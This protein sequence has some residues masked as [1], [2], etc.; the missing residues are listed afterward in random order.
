MVW[1][2][3]KFIVFEGIDGSGKSTQ[4]RLLHEK[5]TINGVANF[6]TAEPTNRPIGKLIRDIFAHRLYGNDATIAALFVADRLEHLTHPEGR[7][8]PSF[9]QGSI[10]YLRSILFIILCLSGDS[11]FIRMGYPGQCNECVYGKTGC[12]CIY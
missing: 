5:L 11:C 8:S 2:G 12:S 3:K 10:G 1:T 7:N 4:A 6:L 9:E